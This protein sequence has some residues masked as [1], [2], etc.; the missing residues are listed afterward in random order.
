MQTKKISFTNQQCRFCFEASFNDLKKLVDLKKTVVVTDEHI[1]AA[2][3]KRFRGWNTIVLHPGEE[4]KIQATVNSVV[5]Q[6]IAMQVDRSWTIVGVGGGVITDIT[7]YVA[8]IYLRGVA[9]GFVPTSL[10]AMVDASVGGKNGV[11]VGLHKNMI[12]TINQPN[13]ILFDTSFLKTLPEAEWRN[14]FAEVIKHG[15][16]LNASLFR[17]LKSHDLT[18]FQNRKSPIDRLVKQNVLLKAKLV[19]QDE[20]ESGKRR[21][22]NFGHTL[23]HAL[24]KKYELKHG[25]AVAVGMSFAA[26]L[27]ANLSG[28]KSVPDLDAAITRY[29][30]PVAINFDKD[31]IFHLLISD[32]KR[33][34]EKINY[35][36]LEKIGKGVIKKIPVNDIYNFL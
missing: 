32:K 28:F 22:L 5:E 12:G 3:P 24:E 23:G 21:L 2:H 11:D 30:L 13:F 34:G 20:F 35:V 26:R 10:L 6:L 16:V 36:L 19:Q 33:E 17:E 9:F 18:S 31:K 7:G 29:G 27:S 1:V 14:G 8:S 15:A 4:F 25:E